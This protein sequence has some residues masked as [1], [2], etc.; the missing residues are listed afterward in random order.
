M[1]DHTLISEYTI[2]VSNCRRVV[3]SQ[4]LLFGNILVQHFFYNIWA[5]IE[6]W[7]GGVSVYHIEVTVEEWF[8]RKTFL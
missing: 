3:Y 1:Y 5:S 8:T 2:I 6:G 7:F 4:N